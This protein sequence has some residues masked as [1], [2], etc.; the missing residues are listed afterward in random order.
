MERLQ[1]NYFP[2]YCS[3]FLKTYLSFSIA[4][5]LARTL[6]VSL[7]NWMT[8]CK[9]FKPDQQARIPSPKPK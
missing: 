2:L 3:K 5:T 9:H 4:A 1:V 7:G 6:Q 8:I